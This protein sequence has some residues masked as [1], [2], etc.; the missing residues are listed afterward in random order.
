MTYN[1]FMWNNIHNENFEQQSNFIK[2]INPDILLLQE[3]LWENENDEKL[4]YFK[5]IGYNYNI[6][7]KNNI[8][9]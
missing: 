7:I 8:R 2:N 9:S 4:Q 6:L 1:V 3:A 5:K